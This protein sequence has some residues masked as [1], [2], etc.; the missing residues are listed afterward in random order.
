MANAL[1]AGRIAILV[2]ILLEPA[3]SIF[4]LVLFETTEFLQPALSE[5]LI[6]FFGCAHRIRRPSTKMAAE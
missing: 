5:A 6:A 4:H 1:D 3:T 2:R